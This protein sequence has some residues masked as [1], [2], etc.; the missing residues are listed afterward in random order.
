MNKILSVLVILVALGLGATSVIFYLRAQKAEKELE[1]IRSSVGCVSKCAT[2]Q[3][4]GTD[5]GDSPQRGPSNGVCPQGIGQGGGDS[6]QEG[7]RPNG[8]SPRKN[9]KDAN[10]VTNLP[11]E[12]TSIKFQGDSLKIIFANAG[13]KPVIAPQDNAL[14]ISPALKTTFHVSGNAVEVHGNFA[15]D[16]F[17]TAILS[18]DWKTADGRTLGRVAR[19]SVRTPKPEPLFNMLSRGLYYPVK[20]FG[21]LRF[22][23]E[24]RFASNL[25]VKISKAYEN[26]LNCYSLESWSAQK[27]MAKVCEGK[28]HL[29]PPYDKTV[30]RMLELDAIFTNR[31]P[32]VY[33][34]EI[35]SDAYVQ[36]WWGGGY[37]L[38]QECLFALTDLGINAA[39]S[40]G[41]GRKAFVSVCRFS[42]GKPVGGASVTVLSHKNQIVASGVTRADGCLCVDFDPAYDN[43]DDTVSGVLVKTADDMA[44]MT[45][46]GDS[47]R[48]GRNDDGSY[49]EIR[50]FVFAERDV[51][52]P[53]ESFDSGVFV[54]SSAK[55]GSDAL[56]GATLDLEFQDGEGVKVASRRVKTDRFGFASAKWDVPKNAAMGMWKVAC[57]IGDKV[58]G[59]AKMRVAFFVAD[60]FRVSL[61]ADKEAWTGLDRAVSFKGDATY[62]FGDKVDGAD[63][64]FSGSVFPAPNPKHW[65]GWTVGAPSD[66]EGVTFKASGTVSGGAFAVQ[67]PGVVTQGVKQAF[68]PVGI[69]AEASVVE[70]GGRAVTVTRILTAFPTDRFIGLRDAEKKGAEV[71][72][73]E[74]ALMPATVDDVV[75][76]ETDTEIDV[77]FEKVEWD[78]SY[79]REGSTY[80]TVWRSSNVPQPRLSRKVKLPVGA[81]AATWRGRVAFNAAEMPSGRYIMTVRLGTRIKTVHDF[82]HWSGEVGERSTSPSALDISSNA[83]KYRPGETAELTFAVPC[84]G[85]AFVVAGAGGIEHSHMAEVKSGKNTVAVPIP[86]GCVAGAYYASITVINSDKSAMRRLAG[87]ARMEIDNSAQR[88]LKV[89]CVLPEKAAPSSEIDV[90]VT[91]A[92]KSGAPRAGRVRLAATDVGVLALTGFATPDPYAY[93]FAKDFKLPFATHD[94]YSQ[95]YPDLKILPNGQI[96]GGADM[97]MASFNRRD[98]KSKQKE[99]ARVVLPPIGVP[100]SGRAT[101]RV[102]LPDHTGAMRFMAVAADEKA[103][104]SADAELVMRNPIT[105]M[106]SAPL[107]AAGGDRF[108]LTVQLFNHDLRDEDWKLN[109]KLPEYLSVNGSHEIRRNGRL[110]KGCSDVVAV[111]VDVDEAAAGAGRI[112]A[113]FELGGAKVVDE[114][115]VTARPIRPAETRVEYFATTN[116][117]PSLPP[118]ETDWLK[119]VRKIDEAASPAFA[120]K[121]S[122]AWLGNYPY[123]CL[124]QTAA[125]AFPFLV[126]ADL[127]A[128][129]FL[130][131]AEFAMARQRV[132]AAYGNIMQMGCGGGFAMWP[133]GDD[134]WVEGS[135]FA[136]H[137]LLEAEKEGFIKID[138]AR[139]GELLGWLADLAEDANEANRVNRS[140]AAYSL[141]VAGDERF[142]NSARNISRVDRPDWATFLAASALVRGG[143]ASEGVDALNAAIA[144]HAWGSGFHAVRRMGMVLF[145]VSRS[146]L[147]EDSQALMPLVARLNSHL[148]GDG[149]AWGTTQDNAWATAGL[150]AF[151][152]GVES[153]RDMKFV[154]VATTGIPKKPFPRPNPITLTRRYLDANGKEVSRIRK[155][156][157]VTVEL[158]LRSPEDI[159]SAVLADILP[160]GLEL[161]DDTFKTRSQKVPGA[162]KS[163]AGFVELHGRSELRDDRYLWFGRISALKDGRRHLLRYRVR[164]V[165]PGTYR[166]PSATVE[167]MYNPDLRGDVEG[168]G[169]FTVE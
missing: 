93:F 165:T 127:K 27:R 83:E 109:V 139:R 98:S 107:F 54:R 145:V 94:A 9:G 28:V 153:P 12:V 11:F 130:S 163:A 6:P 64:K 60:R 114:T 38:D 85:S 105:A 96:G 68:A 20:S 131:D 134:V 110:L 74:F 123:G 164:A 121:D 146:G 50:A 48:D 116:G 128:L 150:A 100:A 40:E 44:F 16:T 148:R 36:G 140:Y 80:R 34:L 53:G 22:P 97:S 167:D 5:N 90:T 151:L 32:G 52:R 161:E 136:C 144:A 169:V 78:Y 149:S 75:V 46:D 69:A 102:R 154:R 79:V 106:V 95:I 58:V 141:A 33:R 118:V 126:A 59:T 129:G 43:K 71:R 84:S 115:F 63:W 10:S 82:W 42:D 67:Y 19:L 2:P 99:T 119:A 56:S 152:N 31:T 111:V 1:E 101:V 89:D 158:T 124:E 104:G 125:A 120:I 29:E 92:D 55:S 86:A 26:N 57:K 18:P 168:D 8:D 155:G 77:S 88:L 72:A 112:A 166:M 147:A 4:N 113:E 30:N 3:K 108:T 87:M 45:I 157:L 23:Y 159:A 160:A 133:D 49:S 91:L 162:E 66:I 117:M 81:A 143:Y 47:M 137:F 13:R 70:A 17:Y 35:K 122:L 65:K 132:E 138:G 61:E 142:L 7:G 37:T 14:S 15:P 39:I 76:N 41:D 51:C 103:T 135:L 62:Y 25:T 156:E 24:S 21:A 73:F